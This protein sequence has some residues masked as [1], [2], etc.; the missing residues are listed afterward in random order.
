MLPG[1]ILR[2]CANSAAI[3]RKPEYALDMV[4]AGISFYGYPPVAEN[5]P[6]LE[7]CMRWTAKIS[8]IKEMDAGEYISYGRTFRTERKT[9][10]ATVTCGYG[11][12]YHRAAGPKAEVL[13][14]GK[15]AKVLGR[16]C[17][18][19][20]LADVSGIPEAKEEDE[21]VLIGRDGND[22]ID[23]EE[24]AAWSGT[25]SYEILLSVGSRVGR[26]FEDRNNTEDRNIIKEDETDDK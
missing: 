2:H 26:V 9:R 19:Q 14:H 13:I 1:T 6:G 25:I 22:R 4:R 7:P 11:D 18:D 15:R 21:V 23:A 3:Q 8:H 20:M 17:M 12:G 5:N 10:V 24:I 16:I